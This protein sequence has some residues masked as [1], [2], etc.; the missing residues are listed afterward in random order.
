[1]AQSLA[2]DLAVI[3]VVDMSQ[4]FAFGNRGFGAQSSATVMR[5]MLSSALNRYCGSTRGCGGAGAICGNGFAPT[6][7]LS[8]SVSKNKSSG[9]APP[10][11]EIRVLAP[12]ERAAARD[13]RTERRT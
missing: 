10:R 8:P 1:M 9:D 7:K 12:L 11:V 3:E 2:V 6:W 4:R 13:A 5:S